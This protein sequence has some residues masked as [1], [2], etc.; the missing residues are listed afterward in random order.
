MSDQNTRILNTYRKLLI[1]KR[2]GAEKCVNQA[3][4][5]GPIKSFQ[6]LSV[7]QM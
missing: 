3:L 4:G 6:G 5:C 2:W 1:E 7:E